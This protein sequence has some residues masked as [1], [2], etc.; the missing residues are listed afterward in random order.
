MPSE[1]RTRRI[2]ELV[3]RIAAQELD[4]A[5]RI[6]LDGLSDR[7][8]VIERRGGGRLILPVDGRITELHILPHGGS[9]FPPHL[10]W[11]L[12]DV[13]DAS[14]ARRI[15]EVRDV[16]ASAIVNRIM[17][18]T[19]E[20]GLAFRAFAHFE[21]VR[22]IVDA[23]R[24]ASDAFEAT[25]LS[26]AAGASIFEELVAPWVR[27][28]DELIT[29]EDVN[30]VFHH[31]TYDR[32]ARKHSRYDLQPGSER[33]QGQFLIEPDPRFGH[34]RTD[35]FLSER[36]RALCRDVLRARLASIAAAPVVRFDEPLGAPLMPFADTLGRK[37][38]VESV[39]YEVRKDLL[40]RTAHVD[41]VVDAILEMSDRIRAE[42]GRELT[43]ETRRKRK[44]G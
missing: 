18:R 32:V 37:P 22:Y 8:V 16:G 27:R 4:Y 41:I 35:P 6:D 42:R 31:H 21:V 44:G 5:D 2:T 25:D 28:I 3:D 7:A 26:A 14:V 40:T 12:G 36:V 30:L 15:H 39:I 34:T 23:N 17:G 43:K 24:L 11:I 13:D 38:A 33:P 9:E 19:L 10:D 1:V 29:G 20:N